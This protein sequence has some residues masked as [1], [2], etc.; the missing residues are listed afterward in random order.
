V[1]AVVVGTDGRLYASRF[2]AATTPPPAPTVSFSKD[3]TTRIFRAYGCNGCHGGS[4][5]L[6]LGAQAFANL[7][8]KPSVGRPNFVR[9]K[10]GDPANSY[11]FMK[12]TGASGIVGSRMPL[13]GAPMKPADVELLR[14]WIL[15]G[16]P[17]N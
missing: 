10:P 6:T 9:V 12:V 1:D 17:N 16:A 4:G 13:G 7:V 3:I 11:V 2:G 15:A 8:N 14:Q 5:G